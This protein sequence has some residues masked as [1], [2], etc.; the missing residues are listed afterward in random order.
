M[1]KT[2]T[3]SEENFKILEVTMKVK[4]YVPMPDKKHTDGAEDPITKINGWPLSQVKKDWFET[5]DI[6]RYHATRNSYEIGN[7]KKVIKI[8]ELEGD[9]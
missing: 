6:N 2:K 7:S 5:H 3:M 4:Y 8:K 1:E 9:G